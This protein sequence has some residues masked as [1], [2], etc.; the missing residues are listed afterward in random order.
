M[1]SASAW[2][3]ASGDADQPPLGQLRLQ[4]AGPGV[5]LADRPGRLPAVSGTLHAGQKCSSPSNRDPQLRHTRTG[6]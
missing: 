1:N 3:R 5:A 4:L 2:L 6:S